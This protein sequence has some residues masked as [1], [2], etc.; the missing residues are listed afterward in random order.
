LVDVGTETRILDHGLNFFLVDLSA[1]GPH[2]NLFTTE[3]HWYGSLKWTV[4]NN[5][6]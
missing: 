5:G 3:S 2:S 6:E 1:F 4:I